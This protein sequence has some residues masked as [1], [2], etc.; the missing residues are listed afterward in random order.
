MSETLDSFKILFEYNAQ[1]KFLGRFNYG[2]ESRD[3]V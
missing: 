3:R 1:G 2:F